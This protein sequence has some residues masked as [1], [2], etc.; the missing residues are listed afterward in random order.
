MKALWFAGCLLLSS[1]AE[2]LPDIR[3]DRA[4]VVVET[5]QGKQWCTL[6][7]QVSSEVSLSIESLMRV[8]EDYERYPRL[9]PKIRET[10]VDRLAEA[11]LVTEKVVISAMG[12]ENTNR[13][14][15]RLVRTD[16]PID[17][18]VVLAW[19]QE[20]TDGTIDLLSGR[21]LLEDRGTALAPVV[22]V[23]YQAR[24]SIPM[25]VPGQDAVVRMFLGGETKSILET[26]FKNA[27][28][29]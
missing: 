15:L 13:F 8:I 5:R 20:W 17:R 2:A 9:F 16:N 10:Q 26:V 7:A 29:R 11:T 21:W 25:R 1:V 6:D 4:L 28:S 19:T 3:V 22:R 24:S 14:T 23:T 27:V 18:T 12:I